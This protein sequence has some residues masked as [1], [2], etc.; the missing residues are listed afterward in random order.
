MTDTI[1]IQLKIGPRSYKVKVAAENESTVRQRV[2]E[3]NEKLN[4]LKK[5]FPGR[6]ENDYLAMTLLDYITSTNNG[7]KNQAAS[8]DKILHQLESINQLLDA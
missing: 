2:H 3:L 8:D 7:H 1:S 6:D 5:M 4:E